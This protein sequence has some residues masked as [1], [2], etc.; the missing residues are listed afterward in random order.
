ML[1]MFEFIKT[2]A[3][4]NLEEVLKRYKNINTLTI[5]KKQK[6]TPSQTERL[7]KI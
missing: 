3:S 1:S 5:Y 6:K 2:L 4:H 7:T